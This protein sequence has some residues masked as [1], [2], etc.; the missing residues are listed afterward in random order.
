MMY[1]L[2]LELAAPEA[3]MRVP[4]AVIGWVL[5]FSRQAFYHWCVNLLSDRDWED[6]H[7]VCRRLI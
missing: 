4:V 1:P 3:L 6:A 5:G 2:V 7:L